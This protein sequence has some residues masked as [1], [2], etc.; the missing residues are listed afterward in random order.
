MEATC[1][2]CQK[3]VLSDARFCQHCGKEV[4]CRVTEKS[5]LGC[6]R[7]LPL[8]ATFCPFCGKD[9]ANVQHAVLLDLSCKKCGSDNVK[10]LPIAYAEGYSMVNLKTTIAGIGIGGGGIGIGVGGADTKGS[11]QTLWS[12]KMAP[13]VLSNYSEIFGVI[14]LVLLILVFGLVTES[15]VASVV[16]GMAAALFWYL[17]HLVDQKNDKTRQEIL[18]WESSFVCLRCGEIFVDEQQYKMKRENGLRAVPEAADE[19]LK[20][21]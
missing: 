3:P 7:E 6:N 1:I 13:P 11:N 5:C 17:S 9:Q 12:R 19:P 2:Q 16:T 8:D 15:F 20:A 18:K 10:K 4:P 14:A 21:E